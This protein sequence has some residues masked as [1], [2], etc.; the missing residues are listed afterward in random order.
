MDREELAKKIML[1]RLDNSSMSGNAE[2]WAVV[3]EK[4][5]TYAY[6]LADAVLR[7]MKKA[8]EAK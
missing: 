5:A 4:N 2:H 3:L 1:R 8:K 7:A 6:E